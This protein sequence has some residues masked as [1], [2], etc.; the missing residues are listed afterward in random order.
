MVAAHRK[1]SLLSLPK[2]TTP[3]VPPCGSGETNAGQNKGTRCLKDRVV[4]VIRGIGSPYGM[5][6]RRKGM[7]LSL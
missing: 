5:D 1:V 6:R 3:L 7:I 2:R 4:E